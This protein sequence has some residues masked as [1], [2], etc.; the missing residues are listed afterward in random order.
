MFAN[1]VREGNMT[2]TSCGWVA[3]SNMNV[4]YSHDTTFAFGSTQP[5][6]LSRETLSRINE[7]EPERKR[8]PSHLGELEHYNQLFNY[9]IDELRRMDETLNKWDARYREDVKI[10]T[11]MLY[12]VVVSQFLSSKRVR[13]KIVSAKLRSVI[14]GSDLSDMELKHEPDRKFRCDTC[15]KTFH[16]SK[17]ARFH[18]RRSGVWGGNGVQRGGVRR[19]YRF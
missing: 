8:A 18:C 6:W 15:Q 7:L 12:P 16:T 11:V 3:R 5:T 10:V 9:G 2:C 19:R 14:S 1:D 17:D 4:E 13:D